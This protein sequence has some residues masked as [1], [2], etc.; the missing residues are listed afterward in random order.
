LL[1][2]VP[3]CEDSKRRLPGSDT[4]WPRLLTINLNTLKTT[5]PQ[6]TG[7]QTTQACD[8]AD[9]VN[10]QDDAYSCN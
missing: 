10:A 4:G 3:F 5:K 6:L 2:G 7:E 8:I 9:F 1:F